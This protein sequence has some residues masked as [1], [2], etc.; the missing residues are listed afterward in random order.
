METSI[1]VKSL[2]LPVSEGLKRL[3]TFSC[4]MD[5]GA[6]VGS[7][8]VFPAHAQAGNVVQIPLKLY[9]VENPSGKGF[10]SIEDFTTFVDKNGEAI[11]Q[12]LNK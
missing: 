7:V 9:P 8:A 3:F 5:N 12:A 2:I 10:K 6:V 4:G 1:C 11:A